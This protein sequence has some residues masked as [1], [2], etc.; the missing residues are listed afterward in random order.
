MHD[1]GGKHVITLL[2]QSRNVITHCKQQLHN[3]NVYMQFEDDNR[4]FKCCLCKTL[5]NHHNNSGYHFDCNLVV[6]NGKQNNISLVFK[7]THNIVD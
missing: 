1:Y 3:P 6:Y 4:G 5:H 2:F 7:R